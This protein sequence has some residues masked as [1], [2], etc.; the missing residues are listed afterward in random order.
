MI[1]EN[2]YLQKNT[3]DLKNLLVYYNTRLIE[4]LKSIELIT[5]AI[6]AKNQND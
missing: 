6:N 1:K 5:E 3:R 4:T 2:Y